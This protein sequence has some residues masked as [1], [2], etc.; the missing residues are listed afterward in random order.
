MFFTHRVCGGSSR[1]RVTYTCLSHVGICVDLL[2]YKVQK[3][4]A[5]VCKASSKRTRR[6][7]IKTTKHPQT[8]WYRQSRSF[9][10]SV[11]EGE[12]FSWSYEQDFVT[13]QFWKPVV[14]MWMCEACRAHQQQTSQRFWVSF[15]EG[16]RSQ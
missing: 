15:N 16:E 7:G 11:T 6:N 10:T 12:S 1:V 5:R 13:S 2:Q 4:S 3:T 8:S 9:H 14:V